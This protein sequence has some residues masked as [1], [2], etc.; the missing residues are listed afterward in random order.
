MVV[1]WGQQFPSWSSAVVDL[2]NSMVMVT[3]VVAVMVMMTVTTLHRIM[4]WQVNKRLWPPNSTVFIGIV[5]PRTKN[6]IGTLW[7][8]FLQERTKV[9]IFPICNGYSKIKTFKFIGIKL[10]KPLTLASSSTVVAKLLASCQTANVATFWFSFTVH[11]ETTTTVS[12][13]QESVCGW[14]TGD[15]SWWGHG[16]VSWRCDSWLGVAW[17][18]NS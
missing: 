1:T 14:P 11:Q 3:M 6:H 13:W 7:H 4:E 2:N 16:I 5:K 15:R 9:S 12:F 10:E 8:F 17:N 18:D